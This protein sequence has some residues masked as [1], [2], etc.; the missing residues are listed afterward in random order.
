ML[1]RTLVAVRFRGERYRTGQLPSAWL[2]GRFSGSFMLNRTV[3]SIDASVPFV[4]DMIYRRLLMLLL[5]PGLITSI[6]PAFPSS[7]CAAASVSLIHG[8]FPWV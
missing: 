4:R 8:L 1:T 2:S 7:L 3:R 6:I 5:R